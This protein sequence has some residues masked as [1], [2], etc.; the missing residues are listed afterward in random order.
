M[1]EIGKLKQV[2]YLNADNVERYRRI[3][4]F[5]FQQNQHLN[6]LLYKSD[7]LEGVRKEGLDDYTSEQLELDLSA[8][9]EWGN[10]SAHQEMSVPKTIEEFKNKFFRYQVTNIGIA[11]EKL[12]NF[13]PS[14]DKN[15]GDLDAHMFERFLEALKKVNSTSGQQLLDSWDDLLV[16]F[17]TIS[18]NATGYITYLTSSKM[19]ELMKT[20]EF[21]PY[22]T[23]FVQYLRE[24]IRKMQQTIT[25]IRE[26]L[27]NVSDDKINEIISLQVAR[28]SKR[29]NFEVQNE[30]ELKNQVLETFSSIRQWFVDQD[31]RPSE[32]TNLIEQTNEAIS[33]ITSIIQTIT[34]SNQQHRSRSKD[35][36]KIAQWFQNLDE[37]VQTESETFDTANKLSSILFGFNNTR[38]VQTTAMEIPNQLDDLWSLSVPAADLTSKSRKNR[39]RSASKPFKLESEKQKAIQERYMAQIKHNQDMWSKYMINN[40]LD[41]SKQDKLPQEMRHDLIR[42]LSRSLMVNSHQVRTKMG[43]ILMIQVKTNE[44]VTIDFG[45]GILT[46]PNAVYKLVGGNTL[47]KR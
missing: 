47:E 16:R 19:E 30:T 10:L 9:V 2:A 41:L 27:N 1:N 4:H 14:E 3:M 20:T 5:C 45:D 22:K 39:A 8:L 18:D 31:R 23:K 15:T 6:S 36:Q 44:S 12:I 28:E 46:M 24:F 25:I 29:L 43:W 11:V 13:L 34:E 42:Y 40:Q 37:D 17:N 38:H 26:A 7:I 32:Y 21:L 35:Y 33:K